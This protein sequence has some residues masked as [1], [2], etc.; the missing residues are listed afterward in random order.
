MLSVTFDDQGGAGLMTLT[1]PLTS[2][3]PGPTSAALKFYVFSAEIAIPLRLMLIPVFHNGPTPPQEQPWHSCKL[4]NCDCP[5][6]GTSNLDSL[7]NIQSY[8]E[9]QQSCLLCTAAV[10]P[11]METSEDCN[12][13]INHASEVGCH[14]RMD[15]AVGV[16]P[17]FLDDSFDGAGC[18][19]DLD[20]LPVLGRD[21][22][23]D[24]LKVKQ[25]HSRLINKKKSK[26]PQLTSVAA[27]FL[28]AQPYLAG[29]GPTS[30]T[31]NLH[32]LAASVSN[33]AINRDPARLRKNNVPI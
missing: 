31:S 17:D 6:I 3:S 18:L 11:T 23:V 7:G 24:F 14:R 16:V 9:R 10:E 19:L 27:D 26:L 25:V 2:A 12:D 5:L 8:T 13:I 15:R 20:P 32:D 22:R 33:N 21:C 29:T 30:V 28:V 1:F 4:G